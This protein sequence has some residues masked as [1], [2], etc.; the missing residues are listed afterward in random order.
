MNFGRPSNFAR[1]EHLD[2]HD[3]FFLNLAEFKLP[4]PSSLPT[5]AHAIIH[6]CAF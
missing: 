2:I 6:P 5:A 3:L 1:L 4:L